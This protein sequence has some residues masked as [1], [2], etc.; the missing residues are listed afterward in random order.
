MKPKDQWLYPSIFYFFFKILQHYLIF[1]HQNFPSIN[2]TA[3]KPKWTSRT[4]NVIMIN[5]VSISR[6][7]FHTF[8]PFSSYLE[9]TT[10][11][12]DMSSAKNFFLISSGSRSRMIMQD[13]KHRLL[14]TFCY[15][16]LR[17]C[18]FLRDDQVWKYVRCCL[19]E[20]CS[21]MQWLILADHETVHG[22]W[23]RFHADL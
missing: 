18:F 2:Q 3:H 6:R 9:F 15:S 19:K 20:T 17:V 4:V 8:C 12:I 7:S 23:H 13:L 16:W 5:S 21:H 11:L 22:N 10:F 1:L 14:N